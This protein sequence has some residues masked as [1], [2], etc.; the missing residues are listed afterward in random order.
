M[1]EADPLREMWTRAGWPA[2]MPLPTQGSLLW[3]AWHTG[4][5]RRA[6]RRWYKAQLNQDH[7]DVDETTGVMMNVLWDDGLGR[8]NWVPLCDIRPRGLGA[9]DPV[10]R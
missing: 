8:D 1:E 7:V 9:E 4:D 10:T 6:K 2:T 5:Y 3:A